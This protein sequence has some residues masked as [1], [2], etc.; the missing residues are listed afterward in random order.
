M[1]TLSQLERFDQLADVG[2]IEISIVAG[3]VSVVIPVHNVL[4]GAASTNYN[5]G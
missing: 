4:E 3:A 1:K 5:R 2:A